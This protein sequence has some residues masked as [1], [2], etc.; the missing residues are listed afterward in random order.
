MRY[1]I[2]ELQVNTSCLYLFFWSIQFT[3]VINFIDTLLSP[4]LRGE[5]T[6]YKDL[7][8]SSIS[9]IAQNIMFSL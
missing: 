4:V 9:S 6:L 5:W 7:N 1:I 3:V 2:N 8:L